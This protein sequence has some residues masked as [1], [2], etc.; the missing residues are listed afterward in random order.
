MRRYG[1]YVLIFLGVFLIALAA[2]VRF[3]V[4]PTVVKAPLTIPSKYTNVLASGSD[5]NYFD[6]ASGKNIKINVW[7]T[8][9]I[10]GDVAAGTDDIAV[11]DE[12]LCL[13]RDD[14][15]HPGC[16]GNGNPALITNSTDRV[17]FN[18]KSGMAVNDAKFG[19]NVDGS[20]QIKHEGLGYKF[21][22]DTEKKTYQYFDTVVGKAFPMKYSGEATIDG[23]D[24]YKFVQHM[25]NEP[26][27]TNNTFPST[28]TNT[29]TV[30]VEPTTGVIVKGQEQLK[31]VLTGRESLN[32]S[33][34]VV[35][36]KL[37]NIVA[38]EG[39][40]TF[41]DDTVKLQAQLADDNLSKI[42]L[43]RLWLPLIALIVG[44]IALGLGIWWFVHN[45]RQP[46][47]VAAGS[48]RRP[49]SGAGRPQQPGEGQEVGPR[50]AG[51]ES[52]WWMGGEGQS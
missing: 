33:S 48:D 50:H 36:P 18:R 34:K 31:Q 1:P 45:R 28:Y 2:I 32:P 37:A 16:V 30:W 22:I 23:V 27:Y 19:G 4:A 41:T 13:T 3:V 39:T 14:G 20:T 35:E 21:P 12:S 46:D 43:V 51:G 9:D 49:D 17:P 44:L 47:G 8:R 25:V 10:T 6:A 29:R 15:S 26:V 7:I 11:Y 38:L 52:G 24:V 40:L 42:K 5:F